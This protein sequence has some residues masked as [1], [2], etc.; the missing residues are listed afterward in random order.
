MKKQTLLI[1][2]VVGLL[3]CQEDSDLDNLK[4]KPQNYNFIYT[5]LHADDITDSIYKQEYLAN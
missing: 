4:N 2:I 1:L 5:L 3:S